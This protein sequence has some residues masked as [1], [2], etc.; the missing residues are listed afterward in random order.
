VILG[1]VMPVMVHSDIPFEAAILW[2][3]MDS[4]HA[5]EEIV[6]RINANTTKLGCRL[7]ALPVIQV[8]Q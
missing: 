4:A 7:T 1:I 3:Q 6:T 2:S 5:D 8:K